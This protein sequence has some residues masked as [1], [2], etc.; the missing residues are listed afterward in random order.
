M[1][2]HKGI[3]I[4]QYSKTSPDLSEIGLEGEFREI[5]AGTKTGVRLCRLPV[6]PKL[7]PG[8]P[9][10]GGR[11]FNKKYRH[12]YP[13]RLVRSSNSSNSGLLTATEKQVHLGRLHMRPIQ[14]HF[15]NN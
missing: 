6:R 12:F 1:A 14:W 10:T 8:P 3:R 4:H 7:W 5:R 2:I 15:K 11:T 9:H 13:D